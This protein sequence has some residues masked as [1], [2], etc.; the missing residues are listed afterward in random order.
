MIYTFLRI[1]LLPIVDFV[2]TNETLETMLISPNG[3]EFGISFETEP[4]F[5]VGQE[6]KP[7]TKEQFDTITSFYNWE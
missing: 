1:E 7:Y 6:Y 5:L 2:Q 3:D 4:S